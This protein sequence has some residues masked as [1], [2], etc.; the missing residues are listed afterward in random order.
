MK[1]KIIIVAL[2]LLQLYSI[3][4]D[5]LY[6]NEFP[7]GDVKLL[8]GPFK[9]ARDLNIEV[10]L[11]YDVDRLLAPYRKEAGLPEKAK[12]YPNWEGLD[13]HVGGHYLSAM[14]MN[15]AATG[16]TECKKRMDY[17]ISE[18]KVCQVANALK[19]PDWGVGYVGGVPNSA[20]LW[21]K[22]KAGEIG[23]IW[24]YWAPYYN[25]HKMFA[26][27]RDAWLY[28]GNTDAKNI[29]LNFCD[30]A[31]SITSGLTDAQME[32]MLGN[33][34]GGMDEVLA[35]AYQITGDEKYLTGAKRYSHKMFLDPLSQG[36]DMLDNKHANTQIPKFIGFERI[37][38]LGHDAKYGKAGSFFWETVTTKRSL[39]FGGN[40]RREHFPA[41]ESC[42]DF[43]NVNDGPE[44]CNS[45]NMLKLTENLFRMH[46]SAKYTDYYER[47]IYNHILSTQHPEHGGYVYFTPARPRHYRVYSAPNE[48]MWCCVGSGM[49][50]HGKYNQFIYTHS[51]DTLYLNLFIASELN[52]K[53]KGVKIKQETGFPDEDQTKLT[54]AEGSSGFKLMVRYPAWVSKGALKIAVN[55]KDVTYSVLPSSYV[56]IDRKWKKGDGIQITLPMHNTIEHLPN[57]PEYIA[58][59][60]GP[61]L[62]GAKTGTEDL[63]GLIADDG[64][65]G[66]SSSG[67]F[68]PV[69][70]API[71]I[72][73]NIQ[74][75]GNKLN[76]VKDKP[77]NFTLNVKMANPA[78]L[79]L[80]P[81]YRIHD[82][83][84]MMYWL[85]L[86]NSGYKAYTDSLVNIEKEKLALEKRTI[87]Q[88]APGEQQPE[89]DHAMLSEKSNKGN[90]L[91]EFFREARDGGYFSYDLATKSETDLSLVVRYWGAEWGNRKFDISIDDE[92]LVTEDNTGKWN[93]SKFQD[94][95]YSIP[96]SMVTGKDHVRVKFLALP[97]STAGAVYYIRLIRNK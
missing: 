40:S 30:W 77:L 28:T 20:A 52:W 63:K 31:I 8:D 33:E 90:N 60:H 70:K 56:C 9:H 68:L 36:I 53:E 59:M 88:V 37:A 73:D 25:I 54:I 38:E 47:T 55:G 80:E 51:K 95:E 78:E 41:K 74:H 15:Y 76:P 97:G 67:E 50:N 10:L 71:L 49:E 39:A 6:P 57:V 2:V 82:A 34:H 12:C 84:Y 13:G 96:N 86:S 45:Y 24:K 26:G 18:L 89:V 91:N 29:F 43:I 44:S 75:I 27:L 1:P 65:W 22:I 64:R 14:A 3:A 48:A 11:K 87:D 19:Y 42:I 72:D 21:P 69:D 81:F 35:D 16:N 79:V 7:L 66:Q 83:R 23:A 61:I 46:P 93:L 62:L 92:K 17:M 85:A 94:V 5:K 58:I 4:Q 32:E